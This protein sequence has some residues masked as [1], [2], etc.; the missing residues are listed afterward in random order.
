MVYTANA[1]IGFYLYLEAFFEKADSYSGLYFWILIG[2]ALER[3]VILCMAD[4]EN[5]N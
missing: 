3:P 5:L 4:C 2:M 1:V